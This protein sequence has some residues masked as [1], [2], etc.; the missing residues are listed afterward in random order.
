MCTKAAVTG[1]PTKNDGKVTIEQLF[2]LQFVIFGLE[3]GI[4]NLA[5]RKNEWMRITN[6][7]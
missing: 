1:R 7:H 6:G 3:I 5:S 4:R 2:Q